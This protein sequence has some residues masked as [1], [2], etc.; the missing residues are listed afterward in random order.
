MKAGF[1]FEFAKVKDHMAQEVA[2]ATTQMAQELS[3]VRDQLAQVCGELEQTRLQLDTLNKMEILSSQSR[4]YADAA[5]MTPTSMSTQPSSVARSATPEPVFCIVDTSRVPEDHIGDAT[6]VMIRKTVEQEMRKSSD[7]SHWRCAAVTRDGRNA[8]RLRIIGRNEEELQKIKSILETRKAPG[9]RVLRDQLYPIKVD[10]MNRMAVFDQEFNVLPGAMETL[11]NENEVQIAKVAWLSRKVN[12]KTYGSM[13]VYLTKRSDVRR[14]LQDH[15]FLVAGESAYTSVFEQISEPEQCYNCQELGHKA[16]S[17]SKN[18]DT[19]HESL[20]NDDQLQDYSVIAIQEPQAHQKDDKLLTVPM[21]HPRWVKMVPIVW[22]K[23]RWPIR[24]MLW[25]NKDIEAEQIPIKTADMTAAV[26]RLP[27]RLV[28]VA[29]VY[30]PG[31]DD[32]AL[33]HTCN[34]LR[35]AV[36]NTR[37]QADR[38]VDVVVVGDFNRHDALWG[39]DDISLTRQGEADPIINLMTDFGLMSLLP[40][41]TKT[42][43]G[44]D[45]ETTVDL[46]LA[47]A[48]IASSTVK[49]MIHDTE[50]GSDHRAIETEFDIFVPVPHVRDRLLLKNAPWREINTR[51]IQA[52]KAYPEERMVQ[53]KTDR[54]MT[55]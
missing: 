14:L 18:R 19:V 34:Y 54:L 52:L 42:W 13:V 36:S 30:V 39:G 55:V 37:R 1:Q 41:G 22:E 50:H 29:S 20:M 46:V 23:G 7:Q 43:S 35:Q 53:Q 24:S 48:D 49:C 31:Q 44:G 9:A 3:Q 11:S 15:Y 17:C 21:G 12:P 27:E 47:S 51:V 32:Q 5:R 45:F 16:F 10:S 4:T 8:N 38:P 26:L 40:R 6:P 25:V 28:L 2:R 33:Q